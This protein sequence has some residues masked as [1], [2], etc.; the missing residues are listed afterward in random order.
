LQLSAGKSSWVKQIN[1]QEV[2]L[3]DR[4]LQISD[5]GDYMGAQNFNFAAKFP[6][7]E[8]F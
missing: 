7:M 4:Q 3:F 5:R 6:Q 2:A 1:G 8:N